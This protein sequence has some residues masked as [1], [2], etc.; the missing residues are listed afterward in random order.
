MKALEKLGVCSD[1]EEEAV[2][3]EVLDQVVAAFGTTLG[4]KADL[5]K[6]L[7]AGRSQPG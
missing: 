2:R 1:C 5:N 3:W 7:K 4:Q 6:Q